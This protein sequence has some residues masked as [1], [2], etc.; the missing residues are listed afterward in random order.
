MSAINQS[1]STS[2][3]NVSTASAAKIPKSFLLPLNLDALLYAEKYLTPTDLANLN[4][5]HRTFINPS[6]SNVVWKEISQRMQVPFNT[7]NP[8]H[9]AANTEANKKTQFNQQ[10]NIKLQVI[11]TVRQINT[12]AI[13]ALPESDAK[14]ISA[15]KDPFIARQEIEKAIDKLEAD[16]KDKDSPLGNFRLHIIGK[17]RFKPNLEEIDIQTVAFLLRSGILKPDLLGKNKRTMYHNL[18]PL[19]GSSCSVAPDF[20]HPE[21]LKMVLDDVKSRGEIPNAFVANL[22]R[23]NVLGSWRD[24]EKIRECLSL[25]L[26]AGFRP[27]KDGV[28]SILRTFFLETSLEE[29]RALKSVLEVTQGL[30][31]NELLA[32][33][34]QYENL[35]QNIIRFKRA[36]AL[37]DLIV[38]HLEYNKENDKKDMFYNN[39]WNFLVEAFLSNF[40]LDISQWIYYPLR[41]EILAVFSPHQTDEALQQAISSALGIS[42][43]ECSALIAQAGSL[44]KHAKEIRVAYEKVKQLVQDLPQAP[45][46]ENALG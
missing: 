34:N 28:I 35:M 4:S 43:K 29:Q 32:E 15:I 6:Q 14:R 7:S 42:E 2:I 24:S 17:L 38:K 23:V 18:S 41:N 21:L 36:L 9:T 39:I 45:A 31:K 22:F 46:S 27:E 40:N 13:T 44:E 26:N 16:Y 11:S 25:L 8:Q 12:Q 33:I 5:V 30:N 1:T 37:S 10:Q 3:V 20:A 19:S